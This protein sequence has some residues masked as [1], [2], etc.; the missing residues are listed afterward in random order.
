VLEPAVIVLRLGQYIGAMI[1]FGSSLFALYALPRTGPS[2]TRALRWLRPLL[3]CSAASLLITCL[4]GLLAQTSVL[5]GSLSEAL[6]L[7]S[8]WAVVTTMGFGRSAVVRAVVASLALLLL[9]LRRP[10]RKSLVTCA[11]LGGL[12]CGSLAWMG[13]GASSEGT[14]GPLHLGADIFHA[15]AAGGWIGALAGFLFLLKRRPDDD[16][17]LDHIRNKALRGFSGIGSALVAVLVVSGL[18]NSWFLVGPTRLSGLWTTPYGRLLSL[19]LMFFFGMLGLAAVNRFR[20]TPAL[21][22]ALGR[23]GAQS[24]PL[25]ELRRS[26]II[27]SS[28]A[29]AVLALVAWFGMMAPVSAQ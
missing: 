15:L 2:E 6:K 27:E 17:E 1:L 28:L 7:S 22:A 12:V 24:A 10:D 11:S 25:A 3:A 8:L 26:L 19:K 20:L 16:A 13:H 14:G 21:G 18:V 29:F 9:L 4:V 23:D 5:A